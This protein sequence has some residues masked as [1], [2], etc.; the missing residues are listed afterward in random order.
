MTPTFVAYPRG[1]RWAAVGFS[2][3]LVV[4]SVLTAIALG[5][6]VR[7]RFTAF[8]VVTLLVFL[9]VMIVFMC[10]LGF[11]TVRVLPSGLWF[12]NGLRTHELPWSDVGEIR[13]GSGAPWPLVVLRGASAGGDHDTMMLMGIQGSDGAYARAQCDALREAVKDA[14]A[15]EGGS[16]DE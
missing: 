6:D 2:L 3:V 11:S 8:Q 1:P 4:G 10:A 12:R 13:F 14:Q 5:P 15:A 7:A 16:G 9:V